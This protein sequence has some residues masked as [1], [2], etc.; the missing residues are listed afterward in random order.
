MSALSHAEAYNLLVATVTPRPIAF[1]STISASGVRNLAPFS[2]FMTGG[3]NPP[4]LVYSPTLDPNGQP[5]DSLRNVVETGEFVVNLVHREMAEGMN[6]TSARYGP[7][8]SEWEPSG[9][10]ALKSVLVAPPRVGESLVQYECR[11]FK[12]V[13]HGDGPSAARYVIGEVVQAHLH[14]SIW[15]EGR[16]DPGAV[17]LISRLGGRD[18]LDVD[19]LETFSLNRPG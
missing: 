9:F 1:V 7:E 16:V 8:E 17:R 12:V 5:K 18:Y 4:S 2:F 14:E 13:E 10:V 11:L 15:K 3:S 6:R 19:A